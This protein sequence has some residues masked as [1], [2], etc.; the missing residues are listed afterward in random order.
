MIPIEDLRPVLRVADHDVERC[1]DLLGEG[2]TLYCLI[3]DSQHPQDQDSIIRRYNA[4]LANQLGN[5]VHRTCAMTVRWLG[6]TAP[7]APGA[8]DQG[9]DEAV[10]EGGGAY[11]DAYDAIDDAAAGLWAPPMAPLRAHTEALMQIVRAVHVFL[12]EH[13]PW[14]M[15]DDPEA[16]APVMR[17]VIEATV[18]AAGMALLLM[19]EEA[20]ALLASMNVTE[21]EAYE[22]MEDG[23]P[24]LRVM[25]SRSIRLIPPVFPRYAGDS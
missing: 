21:D 18:V 9:I 19:P 7:S 25:A 24:T 15:K 23:Q 13:E 12:E 6:G 3:R 11:L 1:V 22:W 8:F 2:P 16:L 14:R 17:T 20:S 5:L 4:D 10:A